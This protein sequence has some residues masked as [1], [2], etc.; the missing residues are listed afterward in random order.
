M[1]TLIDTRLIK[2]L[3]QGEQTF[4]YLEG[5]IY[6]YQYGNYLIHSSTKFASY[7]PL[8]AYEMPTDCERWLVL[9][10]DVGQDITDKLSVNDYC[11]DYGKNECF[12]YENMY[13]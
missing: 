3:P 7:I 13:K 10:G 8:G 9:P 12:V 1:K 6:T 2:L 4:R 5:S 11:V